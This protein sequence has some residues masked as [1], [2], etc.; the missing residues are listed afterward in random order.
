MKGKSIL[1]S[2]GIAATLAVLASGAAISAQDR[3]TLKVPHGLAF[4]EFKGYELWQVI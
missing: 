3:Y 2:V 1:I 4:S